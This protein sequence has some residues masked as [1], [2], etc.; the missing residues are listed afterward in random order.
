MSKHGAELLRALRS[1]EHLASVMNGRQHA[2][3]KITPVMWSELYRECENARVVI[4]Q[5]T[6]ETEQ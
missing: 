5:A 4:E 6:Q 2:G 1:L 3:L